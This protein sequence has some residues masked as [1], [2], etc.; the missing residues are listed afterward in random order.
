MDTGIRG[1]TIACCEVASQTSFKCL[2]R[3]KSWVIPNYLKCTSSVTAKCLPSLLR[4]GSELND[5]GRKRT[6]V[7]NKASSPWDSEM[8]LQT[9]QGLGPGITF[10]FSQAL[11]NQASGMNDAAF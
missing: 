2:E 11:P 9:G 4:V 1:Q 6:A 5:R 3:K 7:L 10:R 8:G